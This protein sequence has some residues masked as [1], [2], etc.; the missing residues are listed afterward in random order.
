MVIFL[1]LENRVRNVP[2]PHNTD[3]VN[4]LRV[5]VRKRCT[6]YEIILRFTTMYGTVIQQLCY[7]ALTDGQAERR[8][9]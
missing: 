9:V 1:I 3:P 6:H 5:V 8:T 2:N 4:G 7:T